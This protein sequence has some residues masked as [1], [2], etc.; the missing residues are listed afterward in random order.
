[1]EMDPEAALRTALDASARV[2]ATKGAEAATAVE[3]AESFE[4]L[5]KWITSGGFLPIAWDDRAHRAP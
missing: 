3:L 4:A 2:I 5:H 1:M